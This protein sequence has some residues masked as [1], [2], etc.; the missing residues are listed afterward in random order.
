MTTATAPQ[1]TRPATPAQQSAGDRPQG[2]RAASVVVTALAALLAVAAAAWVCGGLFG[3]GLAYVVGLVGALVGVCLTAASYGVRPVSLVQYLVL[4]V[5]VVA[6]AAFALAGTDAG[7]GALPGLV[8][9]AVRLGG[10]GQPPVPFDPGWQFLLLVVT[11]VLGAAAVSLAVALNRPALGVFLPAPL[12][13]AAAL[14]QPEENSLLSSAVAL[15]L[16][17]AGLL[18]AHGAE[19][20]RDGAT[21][22][23]F[24]TRRLA[25]G[26][27]LLALLAGAVVG[28][29]TLGFLFPEPAHSPTLPPQRPESQELGSDRVL[30]TVRSSGSG[31]WRVGAL[32]VYDGASWLLPSAD[33]RRL[34]DLSGDGTV[35]G[36]EQAGAAR[37]ATF[38]LAD[39]EGRLLPHLANPRSVTGADARIRYDTRTQALQFA[40]RRPSEGPTYTVEAPA[41]PDDDQLEQAPP[42]PESMEA[43]LDAPPPPDEVERLLEEAPAA[44]L[45]ERFASLRRSLY[46]DLVVAGSGEVVEVPPSRVTEML[47]GGEA[48]PYEITAAE[49]LLARWAG[50]PAR[51]GYGFLGG[52]PSESDDAGLEVRPR[53]GANWVELF[54]DGHGWVPSVDSPQQV[55]ERFGPGAKGSA[56]GAGSASELGLTVYVPVRLE[57]TRFLYEVVRYW[58]LAAA[59]FVAAL[60]VA[61]AFYPGLLKAVRRAHRRRWANER[62]L[63]ERIAVTYAEFRDAATDLNVAAPGTTPVEFLD[64]VEPDAEHAELAWLVTR[65]LWGDLGRDLRVE[66]A[67]AAEDLARSVRRRL[68]KAQSG[69]TVLLAVASR[70]SLR[71][72]YTTE[73]PNGWL[74]PWAA[75][76]RAARPSTP[77]WRLVRRALPIG[78]LVAASVLALAGCSSSDTVDEAAPAP[79]LPQRLAPQTL[80]DYAFQRQLE[81]EDA[82]DRAGEKALVR[83]GRVFTIRDRGAVHGYL[84]VAVFEAGTDATK[85]EVRDGVLSGI[86]AGR[87]E[88]TRLGRE[89]VFELDADRQ[90][91]LVWFAPSGEYFQVLV[92]RQDF[93][94]AGDV[95]ANLLAYQRGEDAAE[96]LDRSVPQLP[97]PRRGGP[98]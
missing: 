61:W 14:V 46:D 80:G 22:G 89:R 37:T 36:V 95:F 51:V 53:H 2:R 43:F 74:R 50:I 66:D 62:G 87:F 85:P 56:S 96:S 92:V 3:G 70:S 57:S 33:S 29:N 39:F 64:T 44:S 40:A 42:P 6:G 82:F 73:V 28:L 60:L 67:D 78:G 21:T 45:W 35:P 90:R 79:R 27:G 41:P 54:F 31:P 25:R 94:E 59:P 68:R 18:V 48:S 5:A 98:R 17:V 55:K 7:F 8:L 84:Q 16:L 97:D 65:A 76:R 91:F 10:L 81:A 72:P 19:L 83:E 24:E 15:L 86:G 77:R 71:D 26:G 38:T 13:F 49:A 47:A 75:Q 30:F 4:P 63:R 69:L 32:D 12:V 88:A 23:R 52:E 1:P 34:R 58:L 9:E 93:E 11:A 20:A